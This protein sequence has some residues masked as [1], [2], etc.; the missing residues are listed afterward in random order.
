MNKLDAA[1]HGRV[2]MKLGVTSRVQAAITIR[3]LGDL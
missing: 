2:L 1:E 3:D